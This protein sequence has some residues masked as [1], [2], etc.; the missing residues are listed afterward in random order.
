[1]LAS[2]I[3]RLA[4][5]LALLA[6]LAGAPLRAEPAPSG[7]EAVADATF[8]EFD[9]IRGNVSFWV[10]V[11][12]EWDRGQVA[13]HDLRHPALVYEVVDLPGDVGERY[14]EEQTL[15]LEEL[16]RDWSGFLAGIELK[17]AE[18]VSLDGSE[19]AWSDYISETIGADALRG[20][21]ER[22]R[23]QRGVRERFREGL[24]RAGRYERRIRE[25]FRDAGLPEDLAFL[26]HV[27]S[28]YRHD[29]R[30][31]A[32]AAGL[33][34]FTRGTGRRFLKIDSTI[35]ERLDPLVAT[36]AAARYLKQ[37]HEQ[38]GSWP[39]AVTSYNHGVEGMM[40]ARERF[41]ADFERIYR[42][43]D[44]RSFGFASRNF[45]AEF[46]AARRIAREPER[47]FP[48]GHAVEA[49]LAVDELRLPH[50]ATPR[51]LARSHGLSL[52]ALAE[53]NPAWVHRA[54]GGDTPLPAGMVVWLPAGSLARAPGR[55]AAE[56][57][58]EEAVH[59]VRRGDTL[60]G[61]AAAHG[62]TVAKLRELN[63][64]P[65]GSDLIRAGQRLVVAVP[66]AAGASERV[67]VVRTG[68]T[69]MRIARAYRVHL[70]ELLAANALAVHTII[71]PGQQLVIP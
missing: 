56:T 67:H 51:S 70:A 60:S 27:E 2:R 68:E 33:W 10:R 28:S 3:V 57:A 20:A 55:A 26:P 15:L 38:L 9:A 23:S 12:S 11:F 45:Y 1:M 8:P 53:L 50:R 47:Y 21:H 17:L 35:D 48:E 30:S 58:P 63:G 37:A 41:G 5:A 42:E 64:M 66:P 49:P 36:H 71:H 61:V 18:G 44:G 14:T 52:E 69:L 24:E 65:R 62:L 6:G 46:L 39:L 25:I 13:I 19:R 16:R 43:Y 40:R 32:G 54:A 4:P 59:V 31:A 7:R 29:A 34:Q 22:V